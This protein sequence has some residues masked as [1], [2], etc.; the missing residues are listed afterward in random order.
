[1]RLFVAVDVDEAVRERISPILSEL[2]ISGVKAVEPENLHI[3]LLFLGEVDELKAEKV[4]KELSEIKFSPFK[5]SFEGVSAF[6]NLNSPRVV[7]VGV[8]DGGELV[9]LADSV[10]QKLKKLGFKRDKEF[11]AHLTVARVKKKNPEI[12]EIIKRNSTRSFGE[13]EVREFKLKQSTLT[14]KGPIYR[15]LKVFR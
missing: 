13:M 14:P 1:M 8:K 5:I 15:D 3:T 9:K 7:W 10:Y 11:K 2:A 6:P 12:S 4:Q